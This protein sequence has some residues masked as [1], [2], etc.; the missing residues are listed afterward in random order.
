MRSV[1]NC[2]TATNNPNTTREN[3]AVFWII[4]ILM[5]VGLVLI[6]LESVLPYGIS[7]ILGLLFII[8]GGVKAIEE[9]GPHLGAIFMTLALGMGMA[10]AF[11]SARWGKNLMT[12]QPPRRK[13][14]KEDEAPA[15]GERVEV[16]Q[17]LHPTG[18]VKW[19]GHRFSA[20]LVE[21]ECEADEGLEVVVCG[22]DSIY[23]LV[24]LPGDAPK[25]I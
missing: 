19:R 5:F 20:R 9:F 21:L 11:L 13:K 7:A 6:M 17:P 25:T 23:L 4:V 16:V 3:N 18:T 1:G 12:L 2:A 10:L 24:E 14:E 8:W 22:R 15:N